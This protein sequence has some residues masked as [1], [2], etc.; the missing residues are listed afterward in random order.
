MPR[1]LQYKLIDEHC[2][3][4]IVFEYTLFKIRGKEAYK[5]VYR[6]ATSVLDY[7]VRA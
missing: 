2:T 3:D 1:E 4:D 5:A 7:K 6:Y